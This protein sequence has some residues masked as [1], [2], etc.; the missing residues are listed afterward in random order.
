MALL[1]PRTIPSSRRYLA[2]VDRRR[3]RPRTTGIHP[4]RLRVLDHGLLWP[5]L[6]FAN[7]ERRPGARNLARLVGGSGNPGFRGAHGGFSHARHLDRAR[8]HTPGRRAPHVGRAGSHGRSGIG[9]VEFPLLFMASGSFSLVRWLCRSVV[10][11]RRCGRR[12][13]LETASG[14][15][16][17][18]SDARGSCGP[19][20]LLTAGIRVSLVHPASDSRGDRAQRR[21]LSAFRLALSRL[22]HRVRG[23]RHLEAKRPLISAVG[24]SP[25]WLSWWFS[26]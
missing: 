3:I 21:T 14:E 15:S 4:S 10:G 25:F 24:G 11:C 2:L 6:G 9:M 19:V 7:L 13:A 16:G 18:G 26:I 17:A 1:L 8:R 12:A 5:V 20:R 22:R 23:Q